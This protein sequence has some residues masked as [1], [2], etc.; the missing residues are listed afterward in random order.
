VLDNGLAISRYGPLLGEARFLARRSPHADFGLVHVSEE[1]MRP[2]GFLYPIRLI[3]RL[4][5]IPI[6]L[7][8]E[9][10]DARLDLQAVLDA[11]YDRAGYDLEI[12]Y[13]KEP[14]PQL[15]GELAAWA[16]ELL[17]SKSLR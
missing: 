16:D 8:P 15:D 13:R 3:G 9:D 17:R 10:P 14:E 4:P 2:R 12:D 5:V 7:K 11:A 6:P 1:S